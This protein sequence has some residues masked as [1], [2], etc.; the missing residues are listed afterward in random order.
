MAMNLSLIPFYSFCFP[1]PNYL[2]NAV[3]YNTPFHE[4][5]RQTW[6]NCD[7]DPETTAELVKRSGS[8][9]SVVPLV[10]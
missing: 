10:A 1:V 6:S 2:S 5:L 8:G 7:W 9:G 3:R 4:S